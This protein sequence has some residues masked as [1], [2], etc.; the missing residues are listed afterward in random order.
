MEGFESK[1]LTDNVNYFERLH[2]D[3]WL[4]LL[5][6]VRRCGGGVNVADG[7]VGRC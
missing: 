1:M 3:L 6:V 2:A 5:F 4:V 7:T